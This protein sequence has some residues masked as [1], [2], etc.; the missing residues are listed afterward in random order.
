MKEDPIVEEI[1]RVRQQMLEECGYD[2]DK[3]LDKLK[4]LE[5]EYQDRLVSAK[6]GPTAQAKGHKPDK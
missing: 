3:M 2:L 4:S 5:G 1:H 6:G